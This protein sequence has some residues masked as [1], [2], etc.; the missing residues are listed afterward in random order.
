MFKTLLRRIVP[1][2]YRPYAYLNALTMKRCKRQVLGGPFAKMRY[3]QGSQ[4][5]C[6]IPKV[7]G[8][9]ERELY[10]VIE[11]LCNSPIDLLIDVGAAEGYYA[12]GMAMRL[13]HLRVTA[14]EMEAHGREL[15]AEMS[16]LN[17]VTDRIEI[18]GK[19]ELDD[20]KRALQK[21]K[22]PALIVDCE[23]Y[24]RVLLNPTEVRE[25]DRTR[26]LV[27]MHE[28]PEPGVTAQL[29]SRFAST[30]MISEIWQ[31]ERCIADYPFR[32]WATP[33]IPLKYKQM[34]VT[35]SRSNRQSWLWM[36]PLQKEI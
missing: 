22:A 13:P 15:L 20:L 36:K 9:Y 3:V 24:E 25:L 4:G 7:L 12:V 33:L 27:E 17:Q 8:I 23:G 34:A 19:C 2:Q 16:R 30:H 1:L 14:Y 32:S 6:L 5:S 21:A 11:E 18:C 35:E 10:Q 26:I 28:I 31:E 29:K